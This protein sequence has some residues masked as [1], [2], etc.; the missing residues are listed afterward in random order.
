MKRR[1]GAER[2]VWTILLV[3]VA[4]CPAPTTTTTT[5]TTT[6]S[7]TTT[8]TTLR[9]DTTPPLTPAG[10]TAGAASCSQIDIGW[11]AST[12][13]GGSGLR[14]YDVY[15]NGIF[16]KL[17]LAPATSTSDTGLT[18]STGY[19]YAVA[20]VDNAGNTSAPSATASTST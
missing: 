15:R 7:T 6:T 5:T 17:V 4:A 8:T 18:A 14:G 16:L 1:W 12:D 10:V 20:A 19:S 13:T 3:V 2:L 11:S 9:P